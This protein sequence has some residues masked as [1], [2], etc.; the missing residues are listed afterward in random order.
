MRPRSL[1]APRT[2]GGTAESTGRWHRRGPRTLSDRYPFAG[3]DR[4]IVWS[5]RG[6]R[7]GCIGVPGSDGHSAPIT[8]VKAAHQQARAAQ[9]ERRGLGDRWAEDAFSEEGLLRGEGD[10]R[11]IFDQTPALIRVV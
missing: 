3:A 7:S 9:H 1:L 2:A 5:A 11:T 8:D 6:R 10:F 4:P